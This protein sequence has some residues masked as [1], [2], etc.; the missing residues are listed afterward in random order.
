MWRNIMRDAGSGRDI[1]ALANLHRRNQS[2]VASYER[3]IF[4]DCFVFV[5]AII[6]ACDGAGANVNALTDFGVAEIG[7]VVGF[8]F[9][10]QPDFFSLNEVAYVRALSNFAPRAQVR[11]RPKY[12]A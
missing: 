3:A 12:R 7:E 2:C 6:V 10:P 5:L 8:R 9:F 11:E 4:N 1:R